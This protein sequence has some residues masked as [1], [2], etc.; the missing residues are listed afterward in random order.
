MFKALPT[1]FLHVML[2]SQVNAKI[3]IYLYF[4]FDLFIF[5]FFPQFHFILLQE[6]IKHSGFATLNDFRL[7]SSI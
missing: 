4:Y 6:E 7:Y 5:I 3:F 1:L 2:S